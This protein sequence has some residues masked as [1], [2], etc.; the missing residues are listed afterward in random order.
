MAFGTHKDISIPS[1]EKA[2]HTGTLIVAPFHAHQVQFGLCFKL[3]WDGTP[4][5]DQ[6]KDCNHL[7]S[8]W[9]IHVNVIAEI[10]LTSKAVL[11]R[12]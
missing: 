9:A 10:A 5:K 1:L 3:I 12:F 11:K 8:N 4:K 7:H 2:L 6:K